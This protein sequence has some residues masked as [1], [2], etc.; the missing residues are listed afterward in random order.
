MTFPMWFSDWYRAKQFAEGKAEG[1]A[2]AIKTLRERGFHAAAAALEALDQEQDAIHK[3]PGER[4]PRLCREEV[5]LGQVRA[6][7]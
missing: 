1:R 3:P 5:R 2:E 7:P 6:K 4:Q